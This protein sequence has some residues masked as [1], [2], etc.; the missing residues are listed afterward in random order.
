MSRITGLVREMFVAHYLGAGLVADCFNVAWKLPNMFRRLF[1]EGA[2]SSAFI[3][4]FSEALEKGGRQEAHLFSSRVLSFTCLILGVFS[5]LM[6]L[7]MPWAM[8]A[9][10]PGFPDPR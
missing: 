10:A 4:L 8:Y 9:F 6:I 7:F 2:L 5:A 3:P 1:A